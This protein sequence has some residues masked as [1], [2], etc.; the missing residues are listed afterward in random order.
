MARA[1][2]RSWMREAPL[3]AGLYAAYTGARLIVT[4]DPAA[5]F[6]NAERIMAWQS[7][8]HIGVERSFNAFVSAR[9]AMALVLCFGYAGMHD[10][11]TLA[12]LVW[13]WR[14]RPEAYAAAR[15]ALIVGCALAL[16]GF[17]LFPLAPPRMMPGFTDTMLAYAQH[18]W[19]GGGAPTNEFAAMPSLH[20]GWSFWCGWQLV[21][22]G[23]ARWT[24]LLGVGYPLFVVVIVVGTANHYV[25][26]IVAGIMVM[27][28]G[29]LAAG[30]LQRVT[31]PARR[32]APASAP[33]LGVR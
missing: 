31:G 14:S 15:A 12:V 26:D 23:R 29:L 28:F 7:A 16:L 3:L 32:A 17:W 8:L 13:L 2:T 33:A 6:G 24:R 11:M 5:A 1:G 18:G 20:A 21:R 19:W 9:P 22:Q 25:L 30:W 10:L 4:G 27:S